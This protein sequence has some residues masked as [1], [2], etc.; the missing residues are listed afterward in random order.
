[1]A[2]EQEREQS[3]RSLI[4]S[5]QEPQPV[6]APQASPTS[7]TVLAPSSMAASTSRVVAAWQR[8]MYT[9]LATSEL[10]IRF[11]PEPRNSKIVINH[12]SS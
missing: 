3:R 2:A 6:P 11:K 1:V 8:Q 9:A 12:S 4:S 10:K 7:S 5:W